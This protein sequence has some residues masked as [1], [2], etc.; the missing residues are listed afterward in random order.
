MELPPDSAEQFALKFVSKKE[1]TDVEE[2]ERVFRESAILTSLKNEHVIHLHEVS[3]RTLMWKIQETKLFLY[4][5]LT[6]VRR[7]QVIDDV[8]HIVMVMEYCPGGELFDQL[9]HRSVS[10]EER[11]GGP[12]HMLL[13]F[14]FKM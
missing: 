11:P 2:V 13:P 12:H 5:L 1:V 10:S 4:R 7:R 6:N 14:F 3:S 8:T 9:E